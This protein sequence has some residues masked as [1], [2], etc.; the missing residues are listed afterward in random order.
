MHIALHDA[1]P[2]IQIGN[3]ELAGMLGQFGGSD[4]AEIMGISALVSMLTRPSS[5][6]IGLSDPDEARRILMNSSWDDGGGS[7]IF[8]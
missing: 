4:G 7:S 8:D 1:D 3:G 6:H 5:I 2:I